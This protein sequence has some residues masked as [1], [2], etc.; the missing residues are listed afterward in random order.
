VI[1]IAAVPEPDAW[2]MLI[3]DIGYFLAC[4]GPARWRASRAPRR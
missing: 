3:V 2:R 4:G 1:S